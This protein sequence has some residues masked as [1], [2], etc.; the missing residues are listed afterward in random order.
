MLDRIIMVTELACIPL[1]ST[2]LLQLLILFDLR[3]KEC[4]RFSLPY[5]MNALK[6]S[7]RN[8]WTWNGG[9]IANRILSSK[10]NTMH[11][12]YQ[13]NFGTLQLEV[14]NLTG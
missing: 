9:A 14:V 7:R 1:S 6:L 13:H 5:V 8:I 3:R 11:Y 4:H 10:R 12:S 2:V